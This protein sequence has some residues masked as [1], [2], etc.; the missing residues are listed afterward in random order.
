ML[1][2]EDS[3]DIDMLRVLA[4]RLDH[5]VTEVWDTRINA[6]YVRN[7]CP[8]QDLDAELER[9]EG[10]FGVGPR[11]HFFGLKKM[12]PDLKGLAILDNDGR[13]RKDA[14]DGGLKT[15]YWRRYE[16][17]NYFVTPAVLRLFVRGHYGD[18]EWFGGLQEKAEEVLS[19]L[20]RERLFAGNQQDYRTWKEATP[21]AGRLL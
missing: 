11:D 9:V 6:F 13:D 14:E 4:E 15:V 3:T 12:L 17:E 7:N 21:G 19:V 1:Y 8:D 5:P 18:T 10:G 20:I 16:T 2:V